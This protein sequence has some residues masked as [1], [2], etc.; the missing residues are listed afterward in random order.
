M[1]KWKYQKLIWEYSNLSEK[2]KVA[3]VTCPSY[4]EDTV[5]AAVQKGIKLIGGMQE[6]I[7]PNEKIVLKPNILVGDSP[8]KII[9]PHPSVFKAVARLVQEVTP[10]LS[11]GDS[12]ASGKPANH[13]QKA[14]LAAP[15]QELNIPIA[16][17]ENGREVHFPA[18]PFIKQF[19]LANGVLDAD[20][21]ISI[22]KFKTHQLTRLTGP[23]K[24]QF[25]CVPGLLKAEFHLKL[26]NPLDF[27]KMLVCLNLYIR[28]RLYIVDGIVAMEGNGPRG[29]DPVKMN[30]LLFSADPVAL[31]ILMCR[32]INLDPAFVPTIKYGSEWGL[33]SSQEEAIEWLGD[34]IEPFIQKRFNVVRQPVQANTVSNMQPFI[35]NLISPRPV[36]DTTRCTECGT[37]VRSCPVTPKAVDWHNGIRLGS[38]TYKYERCIR[39]FCC[40][41]LCPERAISV[42]TPLLGKLL[43]RG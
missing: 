33:G 17:F 32:L 1:L 34:P 8:E 28:P 11:Y 10:T 19:T 38:P 42:K 31:E 27:A 21:L 4:D 20:G 3:L 23:I 5:F 18:S 37:C 30:V 35:R 6:F 22:A 41:E 40:Q 39:C 43:K 12:P 15:A 13:A 7:K 36:I 24:N 26:P 14:G 25:G 29:G 16:D 2:S 9:G